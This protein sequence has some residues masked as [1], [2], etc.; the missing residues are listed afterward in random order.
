VALCP[1]SQ[2][3]T[4]P[5]RCERTSSHGG[6]GRALALVHGVRVL[7]HVRP[8]LLQGDNCVLPSSGQDGREREAGV[9]SPPAAAAPPPH[10]KQVCPPGAHPPG[11]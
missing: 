6:V 2:D 3:G 10:V 5:T 1:L 9:V 7:I 11:V 8:L 4:P